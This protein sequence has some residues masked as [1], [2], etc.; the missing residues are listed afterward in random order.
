M[1]E[2]IIF[3]RM[4]DHDHDVRS[5]VSKVFAD[6][7]YKEMQF[8]SK[9]KD[10][11][12]NAFR[13]A[14]CPEAVFT[15]EISGEIV[16]ILGCSNN[17]TRAMHI[18]ENQMKKHFGFITGHLAYSFLQKEFNTVLTLP[19][20]TGYIEC[21]GTIEKA[22]GRGIGSALLNY[23]I[24]NQPYQEFILEV[25]DTNHVAYRIYKKMGFIEFNRKSE[26]FSKIKGFNQRIYM[27]WSR[28][29]V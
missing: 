1:N 17:K 13:H 21:A 11:L 22:R 14:F 24:Q 12:K 15:A 3:R 27:R 2:Y 25:T 16:S 29:A 6:A 23:V 28:Q 20:N 26:N 18:D 7:Y 19:D 4:A 8:F 10:K 5:D 9:D